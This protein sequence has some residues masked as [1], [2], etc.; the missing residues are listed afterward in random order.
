[1]NYTVGNVKHDK[2]LTQRA[3]RLVTDTTTHTVPKPK[4]RENLGRV[5]P[6]ALRDAIS[7]IPFLIL[8]A[9]AL[10]LSQALSGNR[11]QPKTALEVLLKKPVYDSLKTGTVLRSIKSIS[12][13]H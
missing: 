6:A 13:K 7:G 8:D 2:S 3:D 9:L 11:C 10:L 5:S 4:T 1:M 12:V